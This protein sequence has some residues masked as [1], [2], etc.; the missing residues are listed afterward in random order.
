MTAELNRKIENLIRLGTI[1]AVDHAARRVIVK[2]GGND[3]AWLKWIT[4]RAGNTRTWNPPTVGEQVMILSPSGVLENGLVMPSIFS[5]AHDA[6]SAS[7]SE[8]V[9]D[10]PDGARIA[11]DHASGA[12]TA[13]GIKTATIQA[14]ESITANTPLTHI[15]GDAHIGGNVKIDGTLEIDGLVTY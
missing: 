12:L 6:P 15:T 7:P 1:A 8:H 11:Y 10:Y 9:T 3:T 5:D 2:T 13:T 4:L 14:S